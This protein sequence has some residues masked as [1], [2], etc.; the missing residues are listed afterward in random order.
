MI[1]DASLDLLNPKFDE[2]IFLGP[3]KNKGFEFGYTAGICFY[4]FECLSPAVEFYGGIGLIDDSDPLHTQPHYV[5]PLLRGELP[6][7]V[8]YNIGPVS[9]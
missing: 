5:F 1:R 4:W 7:G 2:A 8:E 6:G 3:N 9:G